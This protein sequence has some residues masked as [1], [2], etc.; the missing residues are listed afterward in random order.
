MKDGS[1]TLDLFQDVGSL[2]GPD[3]R[4]GI[5]VAMVA[6]DD[7][8]RQ[9]NPELKQVVRTATSRVGPRQSLRP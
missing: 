5:L 8:V 3:E 4:F 7:I 1:G 2:S 9:R 6:L